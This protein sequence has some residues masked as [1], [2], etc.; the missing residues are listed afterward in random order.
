MTFDHERLNVYQR[1][2]DFVAWSE[3]ATDD[4]PRALPV[5]DH[6]ARAADSVPLNI[7]R[8]TGSPPGPIDAGFWTSREAPHSNA[9]P[10]SMSWRREEG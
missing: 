4:L 7:A 9:Q 10:A 1:A 5:R 3:R 6:L 2:I 8:A